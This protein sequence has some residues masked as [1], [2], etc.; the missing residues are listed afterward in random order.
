MRCA[1]AGR[2]RSYLPPRSSRRRIL[3]VRCRTKQGAGLGAH[4]RYRLPQN[5]FR[6]SLLSPSGPGFASLRASLSETAEKSLSF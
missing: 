1:A 3:G 6:V 2:M 4:P 5:D